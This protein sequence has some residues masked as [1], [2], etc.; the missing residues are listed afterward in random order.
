M[1]NKNKI[2]Q[3]VALELEWKEKE[4]DERGLK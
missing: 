3:A 1:C 2:R 4:E